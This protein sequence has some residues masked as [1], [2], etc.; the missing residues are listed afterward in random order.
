VYWEGSGKISKL[1]NN[2]L[3]VAISGTHHETN[4]LLQP[5]KLYT[6]YTIVRL[7]IGFNQIYSHD[8]HYILYHC[9]LGTDESEISYVSMYVHVTKDR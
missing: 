6:A 2:F 7:L 4:N 1:K 3:Q 5:E 8:V 9:A